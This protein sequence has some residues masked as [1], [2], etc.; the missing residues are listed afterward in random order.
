M[1]KENISVD[2]TLTSY[3]NSDD[4]NKIRIIL[5]CIFMYKYALHGCGS[6]VPKPL[7]ESLFF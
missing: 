4:N 6:L 7:H 2:S 3:K 5:F 1:K